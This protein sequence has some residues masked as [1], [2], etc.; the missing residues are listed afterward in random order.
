MV[1]CYLAH[2]K[3]VM[4]KLP[5]GRN[6]ERMQFDVRSDDTE[7]IFEFYVNQDW[8]IGIK[9]PTVKMTIEKNWYY[10]KN[11]SKSVGWIRQEA[12]TATSLAN[13]SNFP[14]YQQSVIA[15][16]IKAPDYDFE[17]L[18]AKFSGAKSGQGYGI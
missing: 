14:D 18:D 9:N 7:E 5:V 4:V 13:K 8:S 3:G 17:A 16:L 12:P 6:M 11:Y 15:K 2:E 1:L 10:I